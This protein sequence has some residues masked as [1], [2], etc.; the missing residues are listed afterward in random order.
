MRQQAHATEP[1]F[2]FHEISA[3]DL[4]KFP[5]AIE[6]IYRGR[7]EGLIIRGVFDPET[8]AEV[9]RRVEHGAAPI[10][11]TILPTQD[12]DQAPPVYTLGTLL[13]LERDEERY[14]AAA[15]S[16]RAGCRVLFEGLPDFEERMTAV[17]GA[18]AGG[19]AVEVPPGPG[20]ATYTPATIR[21]LPEGKKIG[22]H[23][24]NDF[25]HQPQARRLAACADVTCQLSYFV[26]LQTPEGGGELVIYGLEWSDIEKL[27]IERG[28]SAPKYP[29]APSGSG[30]A[31]RAVVLV[32]HC[33]SMTLKPGPGD[34][35]LFD[36]GR[37][38]HRITH[39]QGSRPRVTIGGFMVASTDGR[40]V[41]YW[42]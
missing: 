33:D 9:T 13:M 22:L 7:Y 29:G 12:K 24:G 10:E 25:I 2:R 1:L 16:F 11:R 3:A 26:T 4:R 32:E 36:G 20:G 28:E 35:L 19:R 41:Y 42:S 8:V 39:I 37:Y 18:L 27:R 5:N 14:F 31:D 21:V 23:V 40:T 15:A 34:L 17:F 6:D 30:S 38:Y